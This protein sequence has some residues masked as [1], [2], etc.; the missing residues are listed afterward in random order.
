[1]ERRE[2]RDEGRETRD[3]RREVNE[4]SSQFFQSFCDFAG[5]G[6]LR[7]K[8]QEGV[9]P[10]RKLLFFGFALCATLDQPRAHQPPS[11][12]LEPARNSGTAQNTKHN[13][14][15]TRHQNQT[16]PSARC[17]HDW[18]LSSRQAN[19]LVLNTA[20]AKG[21][22]LVGAGTDEGKRASNWA[23]PILIY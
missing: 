23:H 17:S 19:E 18:C 6:K 9:L 3:E 13:H 16:T 1:V 11:Q 14:T 7:R 15:T 2:T 10:E 4:K 20:K 5:N 8:I 12:A 21:T 22:K